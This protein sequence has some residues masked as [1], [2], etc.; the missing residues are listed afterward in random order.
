MNEHEFMKKMHESLNSFDVQTDH[1]SIWFDP[2]IEILK[3]IREQAKVMK[4]PRHFGDYLEDK[5][6]TIS[7]EFLPQIF[8]IEK[9]YAV[10]H[11]SARSQ[12]Q[13]ILIIDKTFGSAL[14]QSDSIGFYPIESV[15]GSIEVKSNL[16]LSEL[17]KSIVSCVNL[18]KTTL[19]GI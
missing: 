18:K 17:R 3:Q 14:Y 19:F 5:V 11:F 13:D 2:V 8:Q 9:G 1:I 15:V 7:F 16:T 10:N 6:R 4:N 12:E